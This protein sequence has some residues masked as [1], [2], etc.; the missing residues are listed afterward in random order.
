[1]TTQFMT[2]DIMHR[3]SNIQGRIK[4]C[5]KAEVIVY[6]LSGAVRLNTDLLMCFGFKWFMKHV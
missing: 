6:S 4:F 2:P 5:W 1:M 3:L